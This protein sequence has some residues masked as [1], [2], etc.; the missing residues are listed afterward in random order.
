MHGLYYNL[1][2]YEIGNLKN[3]TT[4][5]VR[6]QLHGEKK[7]LTKQLFFYGINQQRDRCE[8]KEI[9][10]LEFV[11][12]RWP[13]IALMVESFAL[14]TFRDMVNTIG[15]AQKIVA[16]FFVIFCQN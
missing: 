7:N 12:P 5:V 8:R 10:N 13:A 3:A 16:V 1:H 2:F 6:V 11:L 15:H 4:V 9:R 14:I